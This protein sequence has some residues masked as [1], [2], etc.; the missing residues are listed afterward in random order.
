MQVD[1]W[2]LGITALEMA[3]GEPPLLHEPPLKALLKITTAESPRLQQPQEWSTNFQHFLSRCLNKDV[4]GHVFQ[5]RIF[6]VMCLLPHH[7]YSQVNAR[8]QN[9]Y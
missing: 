4:S 3:D 1:V 8:Y 9:S 2:S 5:L 7:F 6:V